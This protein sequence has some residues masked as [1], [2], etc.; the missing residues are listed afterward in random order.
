MELPRW[1]RLGTQRLGPSQRTMTLQTHEIQD[2]WQRL[3]RRDNISRLNDT[4]DIE[5]THISRAEKWYE[6]SWNENEMTIK[7]QAVLKNLAIEVLKCSLVPTFI[8]R[9]PWYQ[10]L[11]YSDCCADLHT[12]AN[13]LILFKNELK[14]KPIKKLIW[15][16][17]F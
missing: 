13:E 6:N 14:G 12:A 3:H 15:P 7:I 1:L 2:I 8:F 16:I 11:S 5:S 9:P 17:F 4:F 10:R